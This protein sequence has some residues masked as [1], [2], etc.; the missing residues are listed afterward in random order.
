MHDI[1]ASQDEESNGSVTAEIDLISSETSGMSKSAHPAHLI[2]EFINIQIVTSKALSLED[3]SGAVSAYD[4][5]SSDLLY[6]IFG[7]MRDGKTSV[8]C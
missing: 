4:Q 7:E 5:N 6:H 3:L 1:V 2:H 8:T